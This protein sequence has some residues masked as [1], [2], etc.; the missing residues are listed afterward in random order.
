MNL[1]LRS[2]VLAIGGVLA[3]GYGYFALADSTIVGYNHGTMT[4]QA[5]NTIDLSENAGYPATLTNNGVISTGSSFENGSGGD[6]NMNTLI[7][8]GTFFSNFWFING[9]GGTGNIKYSH[10]HRRDYLKIAIQS[11]K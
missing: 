10:K 8:N 3:A 5:G 2:L 11:R 6:N 7:N 4:N 1:K 9:Q